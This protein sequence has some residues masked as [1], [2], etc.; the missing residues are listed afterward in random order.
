MSNKIKI[1]IDNGHGSNTPGK[2]SPDGRLRECFWTR[3]VAAKVVANLRCQGYDAL[4]L[5]PEAE[6]VKLSERV[7]R[8]NYWCDILGKNNVVCVSIHCN[9]AGMGQRW[10]SAQGW[11]VRAST[12][13][14]GYVS[15]GSVKLSDCLFAEAEKIGRKMPK[16]YAN[17]TYWVQNLAICRDTKCPAVLTE[18]FFMDNKEE[19]DW[20]LTDEAIDAVVKLHVDG[21]KKY[22]DSILP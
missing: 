6:D 20:M 7:A 8:V 14:S 1:L 17:K 12:G 15:N 13:K 22:C 9:A 3:E 4:L 5:T 10:M 18:N 11:C 2:R 19:C 21:L 16:Q